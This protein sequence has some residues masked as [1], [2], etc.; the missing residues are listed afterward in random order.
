MAAVALLLAVPAAARA[1]D[2]PPFPILI[3]RVA[4]PYQVSI[5]TDPDA[6]DD[7]SAGG[8]FWVRLKA[9]DGPLPEGTRTTVSIR[10]RDREGAE[11]SAPAAPVR[12]DVT[13]QF[14]ALVMDHEGRFA[15]RVRVTGPLGDATG[16]AETDATYNLRPPPSLV[17]LYAAPF[18]LVG[19]L[20]GTL[21]VS[22]RRSRGSGHGRR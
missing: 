10:P 15:V 5:W 6:T 1:H 20:W 16:E 9:V 13:N 12:G 11:L 3:D 19:I 7:G 18:V 21:L 14:A 2:G 22:R 8:Q 4:G 17:V